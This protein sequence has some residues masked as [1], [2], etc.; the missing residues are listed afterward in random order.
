MRAFILVGLLSVMV[1]ASNLSTLYKFYEKQEYDKG[2]DYAKKNYKKNMDDEKYLIFY[3][4]SCLE[5]DNIDRIT[6]PM[7][8][9]N[10]SKE[11]RENASYF[12]TILLQKQLLKQA[13]MDEKY[14]GDLTLPQTNFVLSRIFNMFVKKQFELKESVYFFKD[15]D[16]K[17]QL[18][19]YQLYID[20]KY[21]IIDI[22]Q[23]EKFTK[24]YRI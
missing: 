12:S 20:K 11:G 23:N 2:C 17:Y 15:K 7:L 21:L 14:L 24:R 22:Y 10:K 18:Y 3:G 4:L 13:V 8:R 19:K 6:T 1:H 16:K 5:T 9:L